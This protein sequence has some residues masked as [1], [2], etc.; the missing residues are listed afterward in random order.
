MKPYKELTRLGRLRRLRL[1]ANKALEEYGMTGSK[2]TFTHYEGNVIFRVDVPGSS[3]NKDRSDP[4]VP[5][6]YNL[7]IL[8]TS[9]AEGIASELTW[10]AALRAEA[11]IPVPEPIPT[12]DGKL[13]TRIV[14]PGVPEG[15]YVSLMRW[16]D[17]RRLTVKSMRPLHLKAWGQLVGRLHQFAAG[18]QAPEG[19]ERPVWDWHGQLG[20]GVLRYPTDELIA[21]MP[22]HFQEPFK[23]V[24]EQTREVMESFGKGPYAYGMIHADMFLENVLFKKGEPRIID[25]ED[26]GFGYWMFD[27]GVVLAQWPWT[28]DF[29]LVRDSFF[30]GYSS[31][32]VL[33]DEQLKHLDLFMAAQHATM[34]LWSS[35]FIRNDPGMLEEY[36]EW[37]NDE[38][39]KLLRYF[40]R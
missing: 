28:E 20:E 37:R 39:N 25:F 30:D 19:F 9:N 27:I 15:K 26:C 24:S 16:V 6:R 29:P 13:L 33:P 14:T 31:V 10:L 34:V 11:G 7:R 36:E 3:L 23:L 5:N 35:A 18:W 12:V 22:P 32:R 38:G 17:G 21:S 8:S 2:L 4:Y 40:D 1:L